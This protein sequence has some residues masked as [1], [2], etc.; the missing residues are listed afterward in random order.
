MLDLS[1]PDAL[2]SL[3]LFVIRILQPFFALLIFYHIFSSMRNHQREEQP[4]IVLDN[5]VTRDRIPVI[6]WENSIGR[7]K[8]SD[9]MLADQTV[10]R[11]HAVLYRRE[12]GWMIAD[13]GSKSGILLNGQ[14]IDKRATVHV[15][16]RMTLGTTT[17]VLQRAERPVKRRGSWFFDKRKKPSISP[18]L[19]LFFV[20]FFHL[21]CALQVCFSSDPF[22]WEALLPFAGVTAAAW[23]LFLLTKTVFHRVSFELKRWPFSFR[24]S[25]CASY[26]ASISRIPLPRWRRWSL[27]CACSVS[28]FGL[29]GTPTG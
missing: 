9:I 3:I 26:P 20:S 21:V 15:G 13:T 11:N 29:S 16:D 18:A 4:L 25:A 10:S 19:L 28:S 14:K 12:E 2:L 1:S 8:T 5:L 6:Y 23:I 7:S 27:G 17:L 24:G 22:S